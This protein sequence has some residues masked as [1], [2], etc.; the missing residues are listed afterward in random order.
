MKVFVKQNN[1]GM[2]TKKIKNIKV[3]RHYGVKVLYL[4]QIMP[5]G[6]R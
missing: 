4:R 6:F 1:L 5:S 3:L 2:Q